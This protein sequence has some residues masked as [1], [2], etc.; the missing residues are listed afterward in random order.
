M[1]DGINVGPHSIHIG[2][3]K[4]LPK[5]EQNIHQVQTVTAVNITER[6]IGRKEKLFENGTEKKE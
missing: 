5:Q 1:N 3:R 6:K 2:R 4:L